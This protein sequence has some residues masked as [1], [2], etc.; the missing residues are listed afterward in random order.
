MN[1]AYTASSSTTH[2]H[3]TAGMS[4]P[5]PVPP[6]GY[7][8]APPPT[9]AHHQPHTGPPQ[10]MAQHGYQPAPQHHSGHHPPPP[11]L[12][13]QHA[14]AYPPHHHSQHLPP[15]PASTML[16]GGHPPPQQLPPTEMARTEGS[17]QRGEKLV[18]KLMPLS[19]VDEKTNRKF[20]WVVSLA[21]VE[22]Q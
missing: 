6:P 16:H 10:S 14:H 9:H 5:M 4:Q 15:P 11:S 18:P 19:L 22:G 20:T 8:H 2:P 7:A 3:S 12:Q 13:P 21:R 17:L 1:T